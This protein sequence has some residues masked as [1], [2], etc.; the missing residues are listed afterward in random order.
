MSW[1]S[2]IIGTSPPP[3]VE[4]SEIRELIA[5]AAASEASHVSTPNVTIEQLAD[6]IELMT[7]DFGKWQDFQAA[8]N[9]YVEEFTEEVRWHRIIRTGV[10]IAGCLLILILLGVLITAIHTGGDWFGENQPYAMTALIVATI[11]G[12]VVIMIALAKGAFA[13]LA[14]RNAGLPMPEHMKQL[15]DAA[16]NLF[17]N[18]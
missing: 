2:R 17:S 10:A 11:T 4:P 8:S 3:V 5:S 15:V 9:K 16:S 12:S 13:T 18:N 6:R 1:F 7:A 14:D